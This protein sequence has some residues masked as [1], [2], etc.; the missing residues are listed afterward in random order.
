MDVSHVDAADWIRHRWDLQARPR[1]PAV[2]DL[3]Q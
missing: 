3:A 1:R 2:H